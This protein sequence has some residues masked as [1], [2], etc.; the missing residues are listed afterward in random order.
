M[1][2]VLGSKGGPSPEGEAEAGEWESRLPVGSAG[3]V[4]AG[5]TRKES[6]ERQPGGREMVFPSRHQCYS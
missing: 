3:S 2:G 4:A 5:G 6:V 1:S